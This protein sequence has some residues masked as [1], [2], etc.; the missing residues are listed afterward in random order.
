MIRASHRSSQFLEWIRSQKC[1]V[2]E[3]DRDVVAHHLRILGGGG[4]GLKPSDYQ[5]LPLAANIHAELHARGEKAF[6]ETL[7]V[8]KF[9]LQIEVMKNVIAFAVA[10]DVDMG[11]LLAVVVNEVDAQMNERKQ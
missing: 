10:N 6:F 3:V 7:R 9:D 2:S 11:R 4:T 8:S 5:C 1:F